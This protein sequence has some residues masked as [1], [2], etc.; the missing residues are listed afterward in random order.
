MKLMR[1]E[2]SDYS[3][4]RDGVTGNNTR[5]KGTLATSVDDHNDSLK[6]HHHELQSRDIVSIKHAQYLEILVF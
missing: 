6:V 3:W 5:E 1:I 2:M 4:S